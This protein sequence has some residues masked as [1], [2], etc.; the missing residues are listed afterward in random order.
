MSRLYQNDAWQEICLRQERCIEK[1]A[2]VRRDSYFQSTM[3]RQLRT[4]RQR[5]LYTEYHGSGSN[6]RQCFYNKELNYQEYDKLFEMAVV[7]DK[8]EVLVNMSF[9][10]LEF[11][12]E[13]TEKA[14][15]EYQG[16]IKKNLR[17]IAVYLVKQEDI[18]RLEV[19]SVQ[20]LWTLEGIDAALDCASQRKET[21]VSCISGE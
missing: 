17:E 4:L 5:I 12:Y 15:E 21:E 13:L 8:L 20:K 1:T 2:N 6:Y 14:R 9:G 7:M 19:I 11:P 18:H 16:Y 10:R 3:T